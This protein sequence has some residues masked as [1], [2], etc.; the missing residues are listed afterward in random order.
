MSYMNY[1]QEDNKWK[2]RTDL[3]KPNYGK[4]DYYELRFEKTVNEWRKY[5]E[6]WKSY[7][8]RFLDFVSDEN[9]KYKLFFYH[10]LLL[11]IFFRYHKVFV[12]A[13]RGSAKCVT[14]DTLLFTENG[15]KEIGS[16]VNYDTEEKEV[17]K[18]VKLLD[19]F[20]EMQNTNVIFVNGK[21][22]T[23]KV[24]TS[25]GF[26]IEG[27]YNHPILVMKEDG[28]F[29][30]KNLEDIQEGDY[31]A[32][33]RGNNVFGNKTNIDVDNAYRY[34]VLTLSENYNEIPED[35]LCSNKEVI[36][37]FLEGLFRNKTVAKV[38]HE[39]MSKQIQIVLSNLG[40]IAS[41]TWNDEIGMYLICIKEVTDDV[42]PY[43]NDNKEEYYL[44]G[45][46][47]LN[48]FWDK[49]SEVEDNENYVYDISVSN[50]FTYCGNS[51]V[52]HNSY[53][54]ILANYLKCI[55][56]PSIKIF[57]CAPGK[58]QS[59][60]ISQEKIEEIWEN[61]PALKNE[62]RH[63]SFQKDYTKLTFQNNSKLD[64]VQMKD[65]ARGGRRHSGSV[66]EIASRDFDGDTLQQVV[67]PLMAVNRTA[68]CGAVDPNELHKSQFYIT[69]AGEKQNFAYKK[70]QEIMREM[71]QTDRKSFNI[72]W[73]Y[74]LPV[75]HGLSDLDSIN[76]EKE[77]ETMSPLGFSR[78][79]LSIWTGSSEDSFVDLEDLNKCRT[80][81]KAEEK[82]SN[83]KKDKDAEYV[84]S[85]DVARVKLFDVSIGKPLKL[86]AS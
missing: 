83:S 35:I 29:D 85:Y 84:L 32:I 54:Q 43:Q 10:R 50:S 27:S 58:Q 30:F 44:H 45:L 1:V 48:Y 72:G 66:E 56:F 62:V 39:K 78:E 38:K 69:T 9:T 18:E 4:K 52:N 76:D 14:G 13:S 42:I 34:G 41:R 11:R 53:L 36:C 37:A 80:L 67:I 71:V 46:N 15:M 86:L 28:Y 5:C 22:K 49:V 74:Q 31:V 59:A 40:V 25:Y 17:D 79:Y 63:H 8:D 20:N 33:S 7:P 61:Y 3:Q 65:T 12:T 60:Q 26:E 57:I 82:A 77:S 64:I 19:G 51:F 75:M 2:N 73:D 55:M 68:S 6:F 23:K 81:S 21:R 70:M 24:K 47:E 16:L